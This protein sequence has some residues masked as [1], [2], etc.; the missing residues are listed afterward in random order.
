M[1]TPENK[2][3]LGTTKIYLFNGNLNL[4]QGRHVF[5]LTK[6]QFNN[7]NENENVININ[8]TSDKREDE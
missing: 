5:K 7:N 4:E 6:E 8:Q 2:S 1:T 3:L